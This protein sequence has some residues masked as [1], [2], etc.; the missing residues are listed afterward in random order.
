M[1][2]CSARSWTSSKYGCTS[3][4]RWWTGSSSLK[5]TVC[6]FVSGFAVAD[7]ALLG[8]FTGIPKPPFFFQNRARF[9]AFA[10]KIV[11]KLISGR[12]PAHGE[13]AFDVEREQRNAMTALINE[14]IPAQ[15]TRPL[16]IFSD[17]D[18]IPAG[19]ALRL[20][21]TCAAPSPIH[22]QMR[23]YIYSF[24]WPYGWGSWRAQ[25]HEWSPR[26]FYMH[27]KATDVILADA[28]W[29]CRSVARYLRLCA[30]FS[31]TQR[32]YCFRYIHEFVTKMQGAI[33]SIVDL[34][35]IN[36]WLRVGFSHADRIGGDRS[37]LSP[38]RIQKVICEGT[39][40]FNMLPE[41]CQ[42]FSSMQSVLIISTVRHMLYVPPG[43]TSSSQLTLSTDFTVQRHALSDAS[44]CVSPS[45]PFRNCLVTSPAGRTV[46]S[47]Y[48][49]TSYE[50]RKGSGSYCPGGA[51]VPAK[52][53]S[54]YR[55]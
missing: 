8:T 5:A 26:E 14:H 37:L 39:D 24:E 36:M 21:K 18:E 17:V 2:C 10:P 54:L 6:A 13:T 9:H 1:R 15:T 34:I 35:S 23:N 41:V 7:H 51:S 43:F 4:T 27:S 45:I 3:L 46:L 42:Y 25:I 32:S 55:V 19:H 53:E 31:D 47:A 44:R 16:V 28:G 48:L 30:A 50:T 12:V 22:L 20:I 49:G 11:Y 52:T 33:S 38:A 40:I 29:H